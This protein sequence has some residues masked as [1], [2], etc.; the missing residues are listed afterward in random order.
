MAAAGA[1]FTRDWEQ[2]G[3][4]TRARHDRGVQYRLEPSGR[5]AW[6]RG[7]RP[8][9]RVGR[10]GLGCLGGGVGMVRARR[11]AGAGGVTP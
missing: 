6:L 1:S 8:T 3:A 7:D 4:T 10:R 9:E 2:R 5:T 11:A